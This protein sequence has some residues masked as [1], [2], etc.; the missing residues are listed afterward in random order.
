MELPHS[1]NRLYI[2]LTPNSL[3][4]FP[5]RLALHHHLRAPSQIK[6]GPQDFIYWKQ[7]G[8]GAFGEVYLVSRE[9]KY[10]AMKILRK[11]KILRQKLQR[12]AKTEQEVLYGMNHPFITKLHYAFQTDQKLFL[13]LEYCPGGDLGH[14]L[15]QKKKLSEDVAKIYIAEIL[16]ALEALHDNM[17][18]YRDLKP[19]NVILDENGHA[20]LT[21][22]GLAKKNVTLH[23]PRRGTARIF[24]GAI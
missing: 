16:L 10:Y 13:V 9:N 18:I 1:L 20:K 7:L 3:D 11:E 19:E 5:F 14:L 24:P 23:K 6:V 8:R 22:F 21:D 2:S 15:Q 12:Y 4:A 17:I